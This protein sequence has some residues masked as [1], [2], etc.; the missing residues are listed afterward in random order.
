[1]PPRPPDERRANSRAVGFAFLLVA[2]DASGVPY[3]DEAYGF[4]CVG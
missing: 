2:L 4:L 3:R 1:L